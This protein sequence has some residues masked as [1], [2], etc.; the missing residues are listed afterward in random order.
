M[1]G[2]I[3]TSSKRAFATRCATRVCCDQS[4]CPC[5]WPLLTRVST[6]DTQTLKGRSGSVSVGYLLP[7]AHKVLFESSKC[8][9][10]MWGLIQNAILPLLPSCWGFSFAL[11]CGFCLFVCFLV[12]SNILLLMAVQ[13]RVAL[14][15]SSQEKMSASPSTLPSLYQGRA[16]LNL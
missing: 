6:G 1:V 14:L 8:L 12:G 11:G 5:G 10:W 9:W 16:I 4:P 15:E 3:A 2:L 7:G 13:Q